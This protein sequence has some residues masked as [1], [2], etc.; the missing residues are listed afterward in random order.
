ML[1]AIVDLNQG[2][3]VLVVDDGSPDGTAQ[4]VKQFATSNNNISIIERS[5]KLGLG[6]AYIAGFKWGLEK[7]YDFIFEMDADFS[8]SPNM[9]PELLKACQQEGV[10]MSVGSRYTS[11]GKVENWPVGRIMMSYFASVYVRLILWLSVSDTTAGFVCY[12]GNVLSQ[13]DF[14]QIEFVGYAFQIEM[15]YAVHLLGYQIAEVPITFK[16][17]IEGVSKMSTAIFNEA[18]VGVWKMRL[19]GWAKN[20]YRNSVY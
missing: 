12:R 6:T 16:D 19:K 9:L 13:I 2:F 15:K 10:G 3:D 14:E 18:F 17:R 1:Q 11:G 20:A 4:L 5:G 8:H 7:A